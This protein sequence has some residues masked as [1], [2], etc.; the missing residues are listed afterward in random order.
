MGRSRAGRTSRQGVGSV[1]FFLYFPNFFIFFFPRCTIIGRLRPVA[2]Y[3]T[4][5][6]NRVQL[7]CHVTLNVNARCRLR[8]PDGAASAERAV[9][10]TFFLGHVGG[11]LRRLACCRRRS[12]VVWRTWPPRAPSLGLGPT[13]R[14]PVANN[15][16]AAADPPLPPPP[17]AHS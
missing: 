4:W 13:E 5:C 1:G 15:N 6:V 12:Y 17:P 14:A 7:F 16:A 11:G 3:F 2:A 9:A 8:K 10:D